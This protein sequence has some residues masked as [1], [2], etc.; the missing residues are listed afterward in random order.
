MAMTRSHGIAP[1]FRYTDT[2]SKAF[3]E[4]RACDAVLANSSRELLHQHVER[5]Y[6]PRGRSRT[7]SYIASGSRSTTYGQLDGSPCASA[8]KLRDLLQGSRPVAEA[9]RRPVAYAARFRRALTTAESR[10]EGERG[11]SK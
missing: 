10:P 5:L 3:A 1:N 8:A 11:L 7:G 4:E 2:L 6:H 9:L